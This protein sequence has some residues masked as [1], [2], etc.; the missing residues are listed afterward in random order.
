MAGRFM[1]EE[2]I[3]GMFLLA[4]FLATGKGG[5]QLRMETERQAFTGLGEW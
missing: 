1:L 5:P 4:H 3:D 2:T